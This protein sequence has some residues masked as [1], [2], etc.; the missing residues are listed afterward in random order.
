MNK[1]T[2]DNFVRVILKSYKSGANTTAIS[3]FLQQEL[4][5]DPH[6]AAR[7]INTGIIASQVSQEQAKKLQDKL[8]AYKVEVSWENLRQ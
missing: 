4:N 5:L 8:K 1:I 6:E 2:T 7:A 3:K